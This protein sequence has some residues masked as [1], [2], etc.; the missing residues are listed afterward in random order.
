MSDDIDPLTIGGRAG[1]KMARAI[2]LAKECR[3]RLVCRSEATANAVQREHGG[4]VTPL[5][6]APPFPW[7]NP[8]QTCY[9]VD[10]RPA[11]EETS[12]AT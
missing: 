2:A 9:A 3:G 10:F 12:D 6:S 8:R 11:P 1:G 5:Y 7:M 4:T